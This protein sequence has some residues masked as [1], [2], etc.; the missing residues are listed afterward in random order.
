MRGVMRESIRLCP[1]QVACDGV[2]LYYR[3]EI[4][5]PCERALK[6]REKRNEALRGER[7]LTYELSRRRS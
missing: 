4:C 5:K 3:R 7:H 6:R 2:Q 1:S